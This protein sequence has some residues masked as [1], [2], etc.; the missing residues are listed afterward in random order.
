MRPSKTGVTEYG[1]MWFKSYKKKQKK[2]S[3]ILRHKRR[4][5][6]YYGLNQLLSSSVCRKKNTK[7]KLFMF[8]AAHPVNYSPGSFCWAAVSLSQ[9][10]HKARVEQ[11]QP[12]AFFILSLWPEIKQCFFGL[13]LPIVPHLPPTKYNK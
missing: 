4:Q 1:A 8:A 13:Q 3:A 2:N 6:D 5:I 7:E 10:G 9:D 12:G 11:V